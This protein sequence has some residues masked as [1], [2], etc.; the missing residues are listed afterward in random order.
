MHGSW[1]NLGWTQYDLINSIY[2]RVEWETR[3]GRS[4]LSHLRQIQQGWTAVLAGGRVN[5]STSNGLS[6]GNGG[7]FIVCFR[8]PTVCTQNNSLCQLRLLNQW[9]SPIHKLLCIA[10]SNQTHPPVFSVT[11]KVRA[12]CSLLNVGHY[13]DFWKPS[14]LTFKLAVNSI[15]WFSI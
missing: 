10:L 1:L 11:L 12:N 13:S 14:S 3:F 2:I 7:S 6:Y 5:V 15:A 4:T 8:H 9:V